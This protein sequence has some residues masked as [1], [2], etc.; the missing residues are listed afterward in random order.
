MGFPSKTLMYCLLILLVGLPGLGAFTA[1]P[2]E[3]ESPAYREG[4]EA[5]DRRDW[6]SA[7]AAFEQAIQEDE[8]SDASTYWLAYAR[9]KGG[10]TAAALEAL[11]QLERDW[12]RSEWRDDA[13]ALRME[14]THSGGRMTEDGAQGDELKLMALA[15]LAQTDSKR[16]MTVI[17]K[18][19]DGEGSDDVKEQ[20]L[21]M[22]GQMG[23]EEGAKLLANVAKD[24]SN[25]E[26]Q[27]TAIQYL[28]VLGGADR[29]ALLDEL[30]AAKVGRSAK[31][32][33]LQ[34]YMIAGAKDRL[35]KAARTETDLE[36]R[37]EAVQLLGTQG[38]VEELWQLYQGDS[39]PRIQEAVLEA[40][41]I[42]GDNRYLKIVARDSSAHSEVRE[43]AIQL[44]G[45]QGEHEALMEIFGSVKDIELQ[46]QIVEALGIAG[47]S[48]ELEVLAQDRSLPREVREEAV[49][50]LGIHGGD[51]VLWRLFQEGDSEL[52]DGILEGLGIAGRSD[53]LL[54]VV[55]N[56]ALPLDTRE[57]AMEALVFTKLKPTVF[58]E[59][60]QDLGE[61]E[62]REGAIELMFISGAIEQLA[63]VARTE[64]D[65]E[66]R[67]TAVQFLA[68]T[69]SPEAAGVFESIL[70][71]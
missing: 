38:A 10:R 47:R 20:A 69:D 12:P 29:L 50:A 28:A 35:L 67:S 7:E 53:R 22:A 52:S 34:A 36:L 15:G 44:L 42:G 4:R 70:E 55:S 19:L 14:L 23:G 11:G 48:K 39:S 58:L 41:M 16:A 56:G 18:I 5:L 49:M 27:E 51:D 43:T 2:M 65:T 61:S 63:Q 1:S 71:E 64:T 37:A 9:A 8:N 57:Q 21:F 40:F 33:I 6:R 24:G 32:A 13:E 46:T 68:M 66:L 17:E 59:L 26:L 3:P 60:Y 31:E 54:S 62:L 25:E 30:Y 45:V